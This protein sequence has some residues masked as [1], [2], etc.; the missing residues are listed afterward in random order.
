MALIITPLSQ[1][2]PAANMQKWNFMENFWEDENKKVKVIEYM[3]N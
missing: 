1:C 3:V 2:V